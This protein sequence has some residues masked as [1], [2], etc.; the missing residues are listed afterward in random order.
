MGV[1]MDGL[2]AAVLVLGV[3]LGGFVDGILLHQVLQWHHMVSD[4]R[5]PPTS[6][7]NLEINTLADGL[8]H[9]ST[10]VLTVIGLAMLWR[11]GRRHIGNWPTGLLIGGLL[12]GWGLFNLVEGVIDHHILGVHHVREGSSAYQL[13]W[14]LGFLAFGAA[15]LVLGWLMMRRSQQASLKRDGGIRASDQ[16]P[17]STRHAGAARRR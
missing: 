16:R 17:G 14:D 9:A 7:R 13:A 10:W 11:Q 15:L 3:A 8:F 1:S 12:A 6:L 5:Y 4:T 2:A